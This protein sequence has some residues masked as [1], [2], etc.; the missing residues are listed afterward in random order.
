[1]RHNRIHII[2]T[3]LLAMLIC[4]RLDPEATPRAT[5]L[6]A[7]RSSH[8]V[9]ERQWTGLYKVVEQERWIPHGR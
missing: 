9:E 6:N 2:S 4:R 8:W 7:D 3:L 5:D 1:M